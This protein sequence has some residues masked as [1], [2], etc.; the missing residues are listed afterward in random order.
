MDLFGKKETTIDDAREWMNNFADEFYKESDMK[1][2][3]FFALLEK[4]KQERWLFIYEVGKLIAE[5][6][7]NNDEY[8]TIQF[9]LIFARMPENELLPFNRKCLES[10]LYLEEI[11]LTIS[12]DELILNRL[13]SV[14]KLAE[15]ALEEEIGYLLNMAD[16]IKKE[17]SKEFELRELE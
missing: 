4:E 1:K 11:S 2:K 13:M 9:S 17:F 12:D 7:Y 10:N 8:S 14:K 16:I 6:D 3:D 5:L 15:N